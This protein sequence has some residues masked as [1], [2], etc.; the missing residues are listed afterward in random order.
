M[1]KDEII[2]VLNQDLEGKHAIVQYLL[3]ACAEDV[4]VG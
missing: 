3:Y 1:D 4:A 2:A